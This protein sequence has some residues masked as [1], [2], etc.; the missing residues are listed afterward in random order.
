MSK[1]QA[2]EALEIKKEI[3]A[4]ADRLTDMILFNHLCKAD[5]VA[6]MAIIDGLSN[7]G[8]SDE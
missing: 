3:E 4:M 5:E 1:Q 7:M 6:A 2:I 8:N